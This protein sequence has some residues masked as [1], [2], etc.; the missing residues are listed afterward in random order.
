[1]I[2]ELETIVHVNLTEFSFGRFVTGECDIGPI[3]Q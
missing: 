3:G 2:G 1:M